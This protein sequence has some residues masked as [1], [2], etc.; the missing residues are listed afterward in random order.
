MAQK[1]RNAE[2]GD[3]QA[4]GSGEPSHPAPA[5]NAIGLLP[6]WFGLFGAPAAWSVQELIDYP[7]AAHTCYPRLYPLPSPTIGHGALWGITMAV[8]VVA[9][10]VAIAAGLVAVHVWRQTREETGGH[11]SWALD[12]GEGRTRFMALSG[13]LTSVA[14][15]LGILAHTATILSVPPCWS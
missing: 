1:T 6:L 3:T 13:L 15:I 12:T 8:S 14:F 2:R 9:L 4:A 10:V 5:R 11:S 7:I